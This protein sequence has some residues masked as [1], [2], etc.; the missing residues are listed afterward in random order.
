[1]THFNV[2]TECNIHPGEGL[3][4]IRFDGRGELRVCTVQGDEEAKSARGMLEYGASCEDVL[5]AIIRLCQESMREG[6]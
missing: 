5:N 6:E 2:Y 3:V 1:M 4:S